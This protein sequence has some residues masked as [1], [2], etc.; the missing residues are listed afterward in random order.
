MAQGDKGGF[1]SGGAWHGHVFDGQWVGSHGGTTEVREPGNGRSLGVV[2]VADASDI[3]R[4]CR[5]AQAAQ[6]SWAA[7]GA[8]ERAAVLR[9]AATCLEAN[10]A[11]W[12]DLVARETGGMASARRRSRSLSCGSSRTGRQRGCAPSLPGATRRLRRRSK[13]Q[14]ATSAQ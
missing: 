11:E 8:R 10:A 2:G 5:A 3:Q 9:A 7:T 1:L 13:T 12:A 14:R 4:A 6:G